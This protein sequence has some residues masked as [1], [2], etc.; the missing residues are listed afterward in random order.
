VR[1]YRFRALALALAVV[2]VAA[3]LAA[4]T[5]AANDSHSP[6]PLTITGPA[7]RIPNRAL[8]RASRIDVSD[9]ATGRPIAPGFVGLSIEYPSVLLYTGADPN[10]VNPVLVQLIRNLAPGQ[11]PVLRIGGDSTDATWWPESS[12]GQPSGVTFSLTPQWLAVTSALA[13]DVGARMIM[14]IDLEADSQ[15]LAGAEGHALV[16]GIGRRQ[17]AALEL[18]NE[19]ELY[20]TFTYFRAPDGRKVPGRAPGYSFGAFTGDFARMAARLPAVPLAGPTIG[21]PGWMRHLPVFLAHVPRIAIVTLHRYPLQLCYVPKGAP[22]Y[23]TIAHLFAASSST[24]LADSVARYAAISHAHRASLR[25]DEMNT[26]SCGGAPGVSDVF[27]SA[28]WS[29]DALFEMARVGV[30]GVNIHTFPG[31]T[32]QLFTFTHA[33]GTWSAFVEPEYYGLLLFARAAPSGARLLELSGGRGA[34]LKAWATRAPDGTIRV[35][36]INETARPR[37]VAVA[38]P[39]PAGARAT[40]ERLQAPGVVAHGGVRLGGQ[41][42]GSA[43]QTG[44][45][46][47]AATLPTVTPIDGRYLVRVP[48]SSVAMVTFAR[49]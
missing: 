30:D 20:G 4:V 2:A 8:A 36:L 33:G 40:I 45:L 13:R 37:L 16:T 21:A 44:Q 42:F 48:G 32:Y 10:A 31:A 46:A 29:V 11:T 34:H 9:V 39:V 27:A 43:T 19:P 17:T 14:G 22:Q 15:A 1:S 38:A 6:S 35:V 12:I 26:V 49:R 25:I 3:A 7:P 28:L 24:G 5:I 23:P 18:G 47:G 41:S